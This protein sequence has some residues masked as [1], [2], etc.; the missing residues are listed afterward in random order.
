MK[1]IEVS[2]TGELDDEINDYKYEDVDKPTFRDFLSFS[3][4]GKD[5]AIQKAR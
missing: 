4:S 5:S 3:I 2:A 1:F